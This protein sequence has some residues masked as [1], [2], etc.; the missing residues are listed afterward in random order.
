MATDPISALRN[1]SIIP[2]TTKTSGAKGS[3]AD[4]LSQATG[5]APKTAAQE[6]EDYVKMTP[7]QRMR[8]DLLKKLGL[9][10]D[11]VAGMSPE[12]RKGVEAKLRELV[13]QQM[14]EASAKQT[15]RIDTVA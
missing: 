1:T 4:A 13:Q 5:A 9:T 6:L 8:A 7:E 2:N 3:F 10:E 12:E 11:D 15:T 14:E